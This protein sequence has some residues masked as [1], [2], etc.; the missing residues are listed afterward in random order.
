MLLEKILQGGSDDLA[1]VLEF[2]VSDKLFRRNSFPAC[3]SDVDSG[4][5]RF[6]FFDI[7]VCHT[8][9]SVV[10]I[11]GILRSGYAVASCL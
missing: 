3:K 2:S 4:A 9:I 5:V 10:L 8:F 7:F 11:R 6:H 1:E